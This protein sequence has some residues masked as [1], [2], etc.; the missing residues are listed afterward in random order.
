MST[1]WKAMPPANVRLLPGL[2]A[3]RERLNYAYLMSLDNQALLQN[4]LLQARLW[5]PRFGNTTHATGN[6]FDD[7]H[8]GWESPTCQVRGHF[9]GHWL[10]A[11]ARHWANTGEAQIKAKADTIVAELARCQEANGGEWA[12]SIPPDY[13]EWAAKGKPTWAPH[14]V[15]HKTLMGLY[16]MYAWAGSAQALQVLARWARWFHRWTGQFTRAQMD[17]LLDVE[18]GG[19]LEVWANLY[20]VTGEAEHLELLR[21]YDRPRLFDPL[22]R[23]EDMLTNMHAN[24]TIPEAHGAARAWEVTGEERWRAIAEAYWRCAVTERGHFC[25]GGQT[26]GEI[27]TPPYQWAARL[28]DKNQEH[29]VVYNMMRLADYLLRWTGDV[30]LADYMELNHYNGIL[31]QQHPGTGQITYFL[32]LE[33]GARKLWGTPRHDF[34]CCHGSLVQAHTL[35]NAYA[36]Y[37]TEEGLAVAGYVPSELRWSWQGV[38]VT[39]RQTRDAK[40]GGGLLNPPPGGATHRPERWAITLQLDCDQPVSFALRLRLPEWATSQA[41][42]SVNG[43]PQPV[44]A[45]RPGWLTLRQAWSHDV[46]RLELPYAVSVCPIPDDP[47][48]VAFMAGPV[49]LAGLCDA[50]RELVVPASMA[51]A[52]ELLTPDNERQWGVWLHGYRAVGQAQGLRFGPLYEITDDPYTVYFPVRKAL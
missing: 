30:R 35:H 1:L 43:Q 28:G 33:P 27:W 42:L 47:Q 17:D 8:W 13:L 29:C 21:R 9:T 49:V 22:L 52:A 44:P 25:T 16:D 4:Y 5:Q 48:R 37:Q 14:Y 2:F 23:G 24:T 6:T 3:D 45:E 11:A 51:D 41:Q 38:P 20:G 31:A 12:G 26:T 39:L 34:W 18:T 15:V 19:M 50:E 40:A 10:S 7:L 32:P 36:Y 46:I